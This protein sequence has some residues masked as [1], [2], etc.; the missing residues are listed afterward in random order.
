MKYLFLTLFL[1]L[2]SL[3]A[4]QIKVAVAANVSYAIDELVKEFN[5]T[6]PDTKIV[7]ILGSSGKL[8]AQISH[9]APYDVFISAN[10]KYPNALYEKQKTA[11]KPKVYALGSLALLSAQKRDLSHGID[12][13]KNK[14]IKKIAIAN[15]K[16]A[17]YG[18]AALEALKNA[19]ILK[20]TKKKFVYGESISQ[21][22]SYAI[23]A[24]DL[25]IVAK[26]SLYS[27]KMSRFK[28][29]INWIEINPKLYTPIKQGV[30]IV[31]NSNESKAFYNF[32]LSEK[33][34]TIFTNYGYLLP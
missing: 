15:P 1:T 22:L 2:S 16:T 5:K 28:K 13:L 26:S 17:P 30:V 33:A 21:T 20:Q 23:K 11:N 7:V 25:G 4:G 3:H 29:G 27:D 12:I 8:T 9:G 32:L 14:N 24:T 18:K 34:R 10:M 31:K 6:N 19:N